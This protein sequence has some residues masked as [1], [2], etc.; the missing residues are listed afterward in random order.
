MRVTPSIAAVLLLAGACQ[1][2]T[3]SLSDEQSSAIADTAVSKVVARLSDA[4]ADRDV[5]LGLS[6]LN[7]RL[8]WAEDDWFTAD[9]DSVT[10]VIEGLFGSMRESK[11]E[12]GT[13]RTEVHGLDTAVV[14]TTFRWLVIDTLGVTNFVDGA[15]NVAVA[16][17]EDGWQIVPMY[18]SRIPR[19]RSR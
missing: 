3:T 8:I 2:A 11:L 16:R 7:S 10:A 13:L 18:A 19:S 15:C 17:T 9:R 5:D 1:P 14:A 12:W 4:V 6:E